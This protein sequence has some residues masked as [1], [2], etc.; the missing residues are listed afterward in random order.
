MNNRIFDISDFTRVRAGGA[1]RVEIIHAE[2]YKVSVMADDFDYIRVEKQGDTLILGRRGID[3][4]LPF[5]SQPEFRVE[6]PDLQEIRLSGATHGQATGFQSK[7]SLSLDISGASHFEVNNYIAADLNLKLSGA[8]HLQGNIQ[9][10]SKAELDISGAS[11]LELTGA[12]IDMVLDVTGASHTDLDRFQVQNA[13]VRLSGASHGTVNI[14]G[15]LDTHLNGASNLH[16]LGS[17]VMGEMEI[18]GASSIQHR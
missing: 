1:V 3:W 16:W 15:K 10:G 12:A 18:T 5:H 9:C 11:H 2:S 14:N 7:Q 17:P 8:S 13:S 4:L 6:M